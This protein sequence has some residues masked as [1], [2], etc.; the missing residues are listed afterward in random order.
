MESLS[1]MLSNIC[2]DFPLVF[3]RV[4]WT[5]LAVHMPMVLAFI[6]N[7]CNFLEDGEDQSPPSRKVAL[8]ALV[9]MCSATI[10][11]ATLEELR[12]MLDSAMSIEGLTR[13]WHIWIVAIALIV[14]MLTNI[15]FYIVVLATVIHAP[16]HSAFRLW[17]LNLSIAALAV[18]ALDALFVLAHIRDLFHEFSLVCFGYERAGLSPGAPWLDRAT[19][20]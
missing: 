7:D 1:N 8:A 19:Q 3:Y 6:A 5:I 12:A 2:A 13:A 17:V 11:L 18:E 20:L 9:I 15:F 14:S 16:V 4:R 10:M